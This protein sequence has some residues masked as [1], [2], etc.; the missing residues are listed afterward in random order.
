MLR[1]CSTVRNYYLR[2]QATDETGI[3]IG[4]PALITFTLPST[5]VFL[6][7]PED[8]AQSPTLTPTFQWQG[9]TEYYTVTINAEEGEWTYHST[10]IEGKS[11]TYSGEGLTRGA[12]YTWYVTPSNELGDP[13]G[14]NSLSWSFSIPPADQITLISPVNTR[15]ET[16]FPVFS[17]NRYAPAT[18][19]N[20]VYRIVI[21]D[22]GGNVIH[23]QDVPAT[24]YTYPS[25]ATGLSYAKKYTWSVKATIAGDEVGTKSADAW[26]VTPFVEGEGTELTISEVDEALRLV[27][28]DYPQ[29]A[30]FT[31][32]I[33]LRIQGESGPL[34]PGQLMEIIEKFKIVNVTE[35]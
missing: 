7:Q 4:E 19:D 25:S 33:L 17:W 12:S 9:E 18:G 32:M 13:V 6:S 22:D 29:F 10:A 21:Q 3:T 5:E 1:S 23:T 2:V 16:V 28:S 30:E 26:F 20:V 11:W 24:S 31:E 15:L 8:G 14:E 34:T 27:L 35:K